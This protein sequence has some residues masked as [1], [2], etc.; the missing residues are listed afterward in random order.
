MFKS[1]NNRD[2]AKTN[3]PHSAEKLNRIVAG[4]SIE[5]IIISDSNVRIDGT[6]KGTVSVKGRLV[7][8]PSGAI[9]GEVDCENAEIEGTIS[10]TIAVNGLLSLKSTARLECDITTKK[11][12]IEPGAVFSGKCIMGGGV[13]KDF[14]GESERSQKQGD[15]EKRAQQN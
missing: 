8:G 3:E 15:A 7:V 4:T 13:V 10:G 9:N 5:G 6:V 14:K 2:M 1:S 12:A 11:L